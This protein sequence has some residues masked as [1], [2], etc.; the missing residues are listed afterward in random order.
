MSLEQAFPQLYGKKHG[1]VRR[2]DMKAFEG[3]L[4]S[5]NFFDRYFRV[6][7]EGLENVP[8]KGGALIVGNHGPGGFDAPFVVKH[9]YEERGRVVRAMADRAVFKMPVYRYYAARFGIVEGNRD[10]AIEMLSDGNL[11]S[12]YPGGI[13]ETVKRPDQKYEIRPFWGKADGFVKVALRAGVPIIPVACIGIDDIAIQIRTAEQMKDS[14]FMRRWQQEMGSDKYSTPM[15]MGLGPGMPLP[16]KLS[17]YMG[18]P[19][20]TG[21]G[22]EAADN[23]EIV[24]EIKERVIVELEK[25]IEHGLAER[26]RGRQ[27]TMRA[28]GMGGRRLIKAAQRMGQSAQAAVVQMQRA[29]AEQRKTAA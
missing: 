9:V 11:M 12:V 28:F 17:Y 25:L 2:L 4:K 24:A 26:E 15:W 21:H 18:W 23:P 14:W 5:L 27:R 1:Y 3:H 16:V 20:H 8:E 22:P 19:V 7:F 13:R 10:Q 6:S 29:A